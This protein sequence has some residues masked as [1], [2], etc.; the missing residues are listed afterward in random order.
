MST[1]T[2][3]VTTVDWSQGKYNSAMSKT[4]SKTKI[5]DDGLRYQS[6]VSGSPFVT[7]TNFNSTTMS[8]FLCGTHRIRSTMTT[9][10]F[11]GK[12]QAVFAPSCKLAKQEDTN[13]A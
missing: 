8:C 7:V 13:G 2:D 5:L 4:A 1:W 6:K 9:R 12:S 10:K 3:D 11:I